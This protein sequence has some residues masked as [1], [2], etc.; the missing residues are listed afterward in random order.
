MS[1]LTHL[2]IMLNF[3]R[4]EEAEGEWSSWEMAPAATTEAMRRGAA[5][6]S[7]G[8]RVERQGLKGGLM[9]HERQG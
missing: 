1:S 9:G 5:V 8:V 6:D 3:V 7:V 4:G 2:G